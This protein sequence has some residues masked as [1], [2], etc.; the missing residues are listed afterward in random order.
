MSIAELVHQITATP[1]CQ[2]F[3]VLGAHPLKRRTLEGIRTHCGV[4]TSVLRHRSSSRPSGAPSRF[5]EGEWVE[6]LDREDIER[7][8]NAQSKTR[9]LLFLPYQ[10]GFCGRKYRV[11]KVMQRMVDDDGVFRPISR[12]VLLAGTDCGGPDGTSGCGRRCPIMW[13]DEW[14]RGATPPAEEHVAGG[15][16]IVRVRSADEIRRSLDGD[17]KRNGLLFMPEMYQWAGKRFAVLKK[18]DKV[19]EYAT[20]AAPAIPVYILKGLQ[21]SGA[22]LGQKA[23]CDRRCSILWHGDWLRD[24]G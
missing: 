22:V 3:N 11:E 1:Q 17:G 13:R 23:P 18:I 12:T 19:F 8:L 21:C 14:L 7:T 5:S 6:V 9:G 20:Y 4:R 10:W 24:D 2:L 16:R 15:E